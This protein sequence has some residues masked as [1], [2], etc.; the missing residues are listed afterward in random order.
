M[1]SHKTVYASGDDIVFRQ[2]VYGG[3]RGRLGGGNVVLQ[4]WIWYR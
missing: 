4:N 2:P 1:L 3:G